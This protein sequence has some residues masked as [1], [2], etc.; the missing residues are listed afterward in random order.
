MNVREQHDTV[1]NQA[2][3]LAAKAAGRDFTP[4][5]LAAATELQR[6]AVELE[7]AVKQFDADQAV[8]SFI[9]GLGITAVSDAPGSD[10]KPMAKLDGPQVNNVEPPAWSTKGR[11][12]SPWVKSTV[13]RIDKLNQ[14][15]GAKALIAGSIDVAAPIFGD[16]TTIAQYPVRLLDLLV[17]RVELSGTNT[18]EFLRQQTRTNNAAPVAD[19]G[20]KPTSIYTVGEVEDRVRVIAHLSEAIPERFLSDHT[21]LSAFLQSELEEGLHRAVEAQV[22]SG[23]GVG[24]NMTGVLNVSGVLTQAFNTNLLTTL[25]K[26]ATTLAVNGEVATAWAIHPSDVETLD[27]LTDNEKRYYYGGPV[28]QLGG[29]SAPGGTNPIWSIPIVQTLAVP[30]GTALLGDWAHMRLVVRED[31]RLDV[32]RSGVLFEKNQVKLRLEGRFGVAVRR[33]GAFCKVTLTGP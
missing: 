10:G 3:A 13:A 26:A 29:V 5:E 17:D 24:E 15:T 4:E 2:R 19:D 21:E 12:G 6:Q 8:K 9:N 14:A 31:A 27:L 32:D 22:V 33:P 30:I 20:L 23:S 28:E 11:T 16:I 1:L 7:P 25:R 18:F